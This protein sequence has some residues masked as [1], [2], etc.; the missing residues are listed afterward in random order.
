[1]LAFKK[2]SLLFF[3]LFL[4][5]NSYAENC[6]YLN[7]KGE[8]KTAEN[9]QLVPYAYRKFSKCEKSEKINK[10]NNS[11]FRAPFQLF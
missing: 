10:E 7:D 6:I 11:N 2:I 9:Y 4:A 3:L 8:L 5:I 1:M